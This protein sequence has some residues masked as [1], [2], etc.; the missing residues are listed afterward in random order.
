MTTTPTITLPST[1]TELRQAL[2]TAIEF[3]QGSPVKNENKLNETLAV[4][5]NFRSY[6]QLAAALNA[7]SAAECTETA[8]EVKYP[9]AFEYH[10]KPNQHI[11]IGLRIDN[12][13]SSEGVIDYTVYSREDRIDDLHTY[14]SESTNAASKKMMKDDLAYLMKSQAEWILE[15]T[16]T[17]DVIAP[18]L[19]PERFNEVC[20]QIRELAADHYA[21][22][23][24]TPTETGTY[25]ANAE[26][27]LTGA[28]HPV[29]AGQLVLI[30]RCAVEE[31]DEL[32]VGMT[33][34]KFTS[35]DAIPD[36]QV[37]AYVVNGEYI[38]VDLQAA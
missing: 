22:L 1:V 18:D 5:L 10:S 25:F 19:E 8:V 36:E 35:A 34:A 31:D 4:A 28:P 29:Y 37:A 15:S 9:I 17:N 21:A 6:D 16:S 2:R 23:V 24:G 33:V 20:E 32:P 14:I 7:A 3:Y 38:P 11:I 27:W 30:P 13:L 26:H 12:D